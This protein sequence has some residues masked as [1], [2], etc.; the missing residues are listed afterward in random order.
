MINRAMYEVTMS[1]D[2]KH[3]VTVRIEDPAG[4]QAALAW[5]RATHTQLLKDDL[6]IDGAE[7]DDDLN[8]A[9]APACGVH[10]VPMVLVNGRKGQF[11]SCHEKM[12]DGTWC[13]YRPTSNQA[14]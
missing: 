4:T 8:E 10:H 9:E 1:T 12:E 13:T 7:P 2:G 14:A 6:P 5:A 11:W 3:T